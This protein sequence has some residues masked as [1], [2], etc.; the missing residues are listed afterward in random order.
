MSSTAG[1]IG[2][3]LVV[4][5]GLFGVTAAYEL[6]RRGH[7]VTV[8]E[9]AG[10]SQPHQNAAT[11][12]ISKLVRLA[13]GYDE[14]YTRLMQECLPIWHQW[15][16]P[17][18]DPTAEP[19]LSDR[20]L[21]HQSGILVGK[22]S[23]ISEP[24]FEHGSLEVM[25]ACGYTPQMLSSPDAF[26]ARYPAWSKGLFQ[27]GFFDADSGWAESSAVLDALR[28]RALRA[29]VVVL[30][31]T[32]DRLL[33]RDAEDR[34]GKR[35]C[36]GALAKSGR[37]L[38]SECVL[39]A[40]GCWTPSLVPQL[41]SVMW[42]AGQTVFHF[43]PA[44]T[45]Q[46][47]FQVPLFPAFCADIQKTGVYGFPAHPSD[48]RV[49]IGLHANGIRFADSPTPERIAAAEEKARVKAEYAVRTYLRRALPSLADRPVVGYRICIYCDTFDGD[50]WMDYDP[51]CENLY[52]AAGG[53][54]HGFKFAPILGR[55]IADGVER[56]PNKY[57]GKFAWRSR[58]R[59]AERS[60]AARQLAE[61]E[62]TSPLRPD[63]KV[64]K[65][66]S[67]L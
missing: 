57:L 43:Q 52:V 22:E 49:K 25:R 19:P 13:Y 66:N 26:S 65:L 34:T 12:D 30:Q 60:D 47:R 3:V 59:A 58:N 39:V 42:A 17:T 35:R 36:V 6:A 1:S 14:V 51:D 18:S 20:P 31:E 16:G 46:D 9:R 40:A 15:N 41:Q 48:G 21:F 32:V 2:D 33:Y 63:V 44:K 61:S 7:R 37:S 8:L 50:F 23:A 5:G 45:E 64:H 10:S 67:K 24:S 56:K 54:G 29:G 27:E 62:T 28:T 53:S 11:C 4:G 38:Y 55:L